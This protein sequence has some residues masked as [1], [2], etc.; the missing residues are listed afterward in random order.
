[1]EFQTFVHNFGTMRVVAK[2]TLRNYWELYPDSEQSLL[3]WYET[4]LRAKWENFNE[5]K[6][7]FGTCKVLGNDRIIFRIKG[8]NYRLV[9]KIS[10][11]NQLIWIRFIGTHSE[12]DLIN[13]KQI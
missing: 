2:S 13:A 12:Y 11:T 3:S 10:F 9:V 8:N 5:V 7:H 4:A 1:L 6:Q